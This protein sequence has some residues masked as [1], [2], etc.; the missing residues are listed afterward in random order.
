MTLST[1]NRFLG[2]ADKEIADFIRLVASKRAM[3]KGEIRL[4]ES[5]KGCFAFETGECICAVNMS[6][7][8]EEINIHG[9]YIDI[10]S[11]ETYSELLNIKQKSGVLAFRGEK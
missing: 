5:S 1:D 9:D 4:I 3:I 6:Q 2:Q 11:G 8:A 7:Y 10:I